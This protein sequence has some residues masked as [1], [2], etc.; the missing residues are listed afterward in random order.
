[1]FPQAVGLAATFDVDVIHNAAKIIAVEGRAKYYAHKAKN[2]RDIYKGLTC[3]SPNINI[4]RDPRWGRGQE[5][6]GEDPY[7]TASMGKAFVRGLQG[8]EKYM[9]LAACAK[10]YAVHSGPESLR[11][12]FDAVASEYDLW[13]TYLPAFEAL[14]TEARVEAVMGAYNRTNGEA[15]CASKTLLNEILRER[16]GFTGHVVSDCWAI[17]DF[18]EKHGLTRDMV[19]SVALAVKNGCDL[20][21][22]HCFLHLMQAYQDGLVT[23]ADIDAACVRLFTTR[24][25]LGLF[26]EDD[27]PSIFTPTKSWRAA[28]TPKPPCKPAATAWCFCKIK[29]IYCPLTTAPS[30]PSASSAPTPTAVICSWATTTARPT[31]ASPFWKVSTGMPRV[32]ICACCTPRAAIYGARRWAAYRRRATACPKP[33]R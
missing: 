22:G 7:L 16:W 5:T 1:V 29:I 33:W 6:Y 10:H 11:H 19:E 14:V 24:F 21:C 2:D 31:A 20:N 28:N 32:R 17:K 12:E 25:K 15:C 3:W 26:D 27:T 4:F 8:D 30:R 23:E 18:H 13:D 9:K